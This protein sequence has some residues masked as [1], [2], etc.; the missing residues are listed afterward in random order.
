MHFSHDSQKYIHVAVEIAD[1]GLT[2]VVR[3]QTTGPL[4]ADRN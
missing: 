4:D 1:F 2:S 3:K